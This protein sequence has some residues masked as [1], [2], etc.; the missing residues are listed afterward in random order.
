MDL[1]EIDY[2]SGVYFLGW[3]FYNL[4]KCQF[5]TFVKVIKF[6]TFNYLKMEEIKYKLNSNNVMIVTE[7]ISLLLNSIAKLVKHN[8]NSYDLEQHFNLLHE[9]CISA[10]I[11]VSSAACCGFLK[12]LKDGLMD[13]NPSLS[14]TMAMLVSVEYVIGCIF[15]YFS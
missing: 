6:V 4:N 8:K 15:L 1:I 11:I 5:V 10:N 9:Q 12:L 2:N 7:A 3:Q 14:S 13:I